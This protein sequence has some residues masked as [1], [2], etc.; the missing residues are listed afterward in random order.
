MKHKNIKNILL[1]NFFILFLVW[2][3]VKLSDYI[4]AKTILNSNIIEN[5]TI[6][7]LS[8]SALTPNQQKIILFITMTIIIVNLIIREIIPYYERKKK[9][10]NNLT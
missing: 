6:D 7:K 2:T 10:K 3:L 4:L 1:K 5:I 8:N 9:N